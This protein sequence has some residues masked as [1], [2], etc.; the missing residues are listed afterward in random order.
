VEYFVKTGIV[1]LG[2]TLP[3]TLLV[4][5]GPVAILQAA[6]VS[7]ATFG[8]IYTAGLRLGL[9]QRFAATLGAGGA[10]CGVSAAIAVAGS[11]GARREHA[12]VAITIVI[13]WAIVMIFALPLVA[14]ALGLP[15]GVAGAWIGTS[16]FADAA[17]LAAAQAYGGYA[18]QVPGIS[19]SPDA[20]VTA[21]TLMKVIGRDLWI[22]IWAFVLSLVAVT[23]WEASGVDTRTGA[24]EIW[25]RFP[26]F[27]LG[28]LLTSALI[29]A[30]SAAYGPADTQRV[31]KPELMAPI[32]TLRTWAFVFCFLS[33]GL[34]T[35]WRDLAHAGLRPF[36]AFSA[37]VLVNV[38]L[39]YLLSAV[40]FADHWQAL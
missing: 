14:R 19:G 38:L 15:T 13:F 2:A 1:L 11:V 3:L 5:A 28:F 4:T 24:R 33:I 37:G 25:A 32:K 35:R 36:L 12:P 34:T 6:I 7:L 9:E 31:L 17:G 26:K 20:A 39:G 27:V 8:V 22:G 18:G 29:A 10:V 23:R 30:L 16:E 40:V 21:F